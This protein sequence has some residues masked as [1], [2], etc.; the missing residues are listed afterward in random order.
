MFVS[1]TFRCVQ[2]IGVGV[3]L[4]GIAI[5]VGFSGCAS[6]GSRTGDAAPASGAIEQLHLLVTA[7]ALDMDGKPGP[8][9]FGARVYASSRTSAEAIPITGGKL[10]IAMYDGTVQSAE[11]GAGKPLQ[12]WLFEP[13]KL[14]GLVQRTAIGVGY[15]FALAWGE[16][17]PTQNRVTIIARY[18]SGKAS[19]IVSAPGIVPLITN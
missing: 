14:R 1:R 5:V 19:A 9:G 15:A 13:K 4:A 18:H 7:V 2:S 12:T 3:A 6:N 10:E 8:D 17:K 16:N 11:V